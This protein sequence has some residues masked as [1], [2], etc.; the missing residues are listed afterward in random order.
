MPLLRSVTLDEDGRLAA[1]HGCNVLD[2]APEPEFDALVK[3]AAR[4]TN[5]P[6]A[7]VS[8]V[9]ESRQWFKARVGTEVR[10]TP[11][12]ISF[13]G[14]TITQQT[15]LVIQDAREDPRFASNP[16]VTGDP[17]VVF[18]AGWPL[19]TYDGH[20]LGSL[21][22]IDHVPRMLTVAQHEAMALLARQVV[23]SLELRRAPTQGIEIVSPLLELATKAATLDIDRSSRVQLSQLVVHD[24]KNPLTAIASNATYVLETANINADQSEA[25]RDVL[26]AAKRMQAMLLDLLDIGRATI[27]DHEMIARKEVLD[28]GKLVQPLIGRAVDPETGVKMV[29][30]LE[31]RLSVRADPTLLSRM[32]VNLIDNAQRHAPRNSTVTVHA[33]SVRDHVLIAVAD[34]GTGIADG[35]KKRVFDKYVQ[36]TAGDARSGHGLGLAFCK[37]AAEAHGGHVYVEDNAPRGARFCFRLPN[38]MPVV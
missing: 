9:D 28:L 35:D 10:E 27:G 21:C 30:D 26:N 36:L 25:L 24:L 15:P 6:I 31:P 5:T 23:L 22:V 29:V 34:T 7:L 2:S 11:R 19:V 13:C 17:H 18:Y 14:Y 37:L 33:H 8:L 12:S 1:L 16:L 4:L 3:H 32:L 38:A 20:A